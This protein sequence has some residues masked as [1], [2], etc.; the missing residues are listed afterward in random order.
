MLAEKLGFR[1][2]VS[3]GVSLDSVAALE[4]RLVCLCGGRSGDDFLV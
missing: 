1:L 2:H 4:R 3:R